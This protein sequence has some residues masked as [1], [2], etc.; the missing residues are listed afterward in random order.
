MKLVYMI[1]SLVFRTLALL[2]LSCALVRPLQL[3]KVE[4]NKK[5]NCINI[6]LFYLL[7]YRMRLLIH[8][9]LYVHFVKRRNKFLLLRTD[10]LLIAH[11]LFLKEYY[12]FQANAKNSQTNWTHMYAWVYAWLS[13][14]SGRNHCTAFCVYLSCI[15]FCMVFK[16]SYDIKTRYKLFS[17]VFH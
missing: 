9:D 7:E 4:T 2:F 12:R 14:S 5:S 8:S 16:V 1:F 15:L 11:K 6:S 3:D 10:F 13:C 17:V